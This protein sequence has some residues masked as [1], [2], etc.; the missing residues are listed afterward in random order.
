MSDEPLVA[1]HTALEQIRKADQRWEAA[2]RAFDDYQTRL[3][4]L[5]DAA[6]NRSRALMLGELANIKQNPRPGASSIR[7]LA[8][9]LAPTSNRPGPKALWQRF[10]QAVKQIGVALE[11]GEILTIAQAFGDLATIAGE[12]ADSYAT[13]QQ[14]QHGRRSA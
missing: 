2:I 4:T 3:R 13:A 14:P 8:P 10:D 5:A 1:A 9:E 6:R 12:L 7:A 11:H